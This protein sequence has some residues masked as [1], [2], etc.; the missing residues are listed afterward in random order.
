MAVLA[1][2]LIVLELSTAEVPN[3]AGTWT[4]NWNGYK[5][6]KGYVEALKEG[7]PE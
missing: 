5:E 6:V 7:S 4:G 2:A 3:L 1:L